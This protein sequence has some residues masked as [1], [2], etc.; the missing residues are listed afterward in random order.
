MQDIKLHDRFFPL[1]GDGRKRQTVR[2]GRRDFQL[3]EAKLL[4][5]E[6]EAE[7]TIT[8]VKYKKL[9]DLTEEEAIED[10][11]NSRDELIEALRDI[12][13]EIDRDTVVTMIGFLFRGYNRSPREPFVTSHMVMDKLSYD[14]AREL[15]SLLQKKHEDRSFFMSS[16]GFAWAVHV[17]PREELNTSFTK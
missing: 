2:K 16:D 4:G 10:G 17:R 7:I 13:D 15:L 6:W 1:I 14:R 11:F 8:S 12:Y 9:K 3:G 5:N